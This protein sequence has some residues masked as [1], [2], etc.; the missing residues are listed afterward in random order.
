MTGGLIN[1]VSYGVDDLY[2]T[3]SPQITLFKI[4]YR[5][6]TNFSKESVFLQIS[7]INF[8]KEVEIEI[9]KIADLLSNTYLQLNI[10][11]MNILKTDTA[12]DLTNNEYNVLSS[13]FYPK[14]PEGEPDYV[15]DYEIIKKFMVV[16]MTGYRTALNNF[17]IRNQTVLQYINSILDSIQ[18][19]ITKPETIQS[20]ELTLNSA[21]DYEFKKLE[22]AP[23]NSPTY[24]SHKNIPILDYKLSDI[25]YILNYIKNSV[26]TT[27]LVIYGFIDVS[28]I[29]V[30]DILIIV[31]NAV[32]T[33]K[34]VMKYYFN[35][36][37]RII[38]Q[39]KEAESKYAKFA[40]V[41]RLGHAIIDYI[42]V[43]IGGEVID[44]HYGDWINLWNELTNS[45]DQKKLYE[46][47]IGQV[48]ELTT[49]DRKQKPMYT[50]Y[51][52]LSFWFCN[53]DGLAFP[54]IA[55][56]FNKFYI[57]IKFKKLEDCAYIEPLPTE[58]Q[59][60]NPIDFTDNALQLTDIWNNLN[61]VMTGGLLIDYIYLDPTERTRFA[62]YAHEYLINTVEITNFTNITDDKIINT[63]NFTGPSKELIWVTQKTAYIDNYNSNYKSLWFDYSTGVKNNIDRNPIFNT[64]LSFN[65]YDMFNKSMKLN[66]RKYFNFVQPYS[67]HTKCPSDGVNSY[68]FSL[69]PQE[70]QPSGSCNFNIIKI[71]LM[72][73]EIDK[74][75]FIY[76]L[77]DIDPN[78]IPYSE[79]DEVLSTP[80][81]LRIYSIRIGVLRVMNGFSA[82][83][84][85]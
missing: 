3:G 33:C 53:T 84:Y 44:K 58:D 76:N 12:A 1:I 59:S 35:N 66:S 54:M 10:P 36:S 21:L 13:P 81:N 48:E 68:S 22:N 38:N 82:L 70:Q 11:A 71:P 26:S 60:G 17:E 49:Y 73:F 56:Q 43:R 65:G 16:N 52:P 8:D 57:T 4:V 85:Y 41:S 37:L 55:L 19:S 45:E 20:Y 18:A 23:P 72:T 67:H 24:E 42:E 31:E 51:L 29:T 47:M 39:N 40:W 46:R 2:L 74:N 80:I 9:P 50:I 14:K 69:F 7:D 32:Q 6:H 27:G 61:M 15:V 28:N 77:S 75:M 5:R 34:K 63:L 79:N 30:N 78:I 62:K 64:E 83:A 25:T